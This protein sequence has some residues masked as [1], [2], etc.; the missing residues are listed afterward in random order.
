MTVLPAVVAHIKL[1]I[2]R[3]LSCWRCVGPYMAHDLG[4]HH[5][6]F[7]S[8]LQLYKSV[9]DDGCQGT[10]LQFDVIFLQLPVFIQ[11][12][13][14]N[15]RSFSDRLPPVPYL[16]FKWPDLS[17]IYFLIVSVLTINFELWKLEILIL[18][19]QIWHLFLYFF[20][21]NFWSSFCPSKSI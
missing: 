18:A 13:W 7:G 20:T 16:G 15:C 14:N 6:P 19:M 10:F 1:H 21:C 3:T 2:S 8:L 4:R 17:P 9:T 12:S 5:G 11:S